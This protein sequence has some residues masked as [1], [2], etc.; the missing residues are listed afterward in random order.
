MM[1]PELYQKH[2]LYFIGL[3][4]VKTKYTFRWQPR[5]KFGIKL[6][7]SGKETVD[8]KKQVTWQDLSRSFDLFCIAFS[9]VAFLC[10]N[11]ASVIKYCVKFVKN[12]QR[13]EKNIN[14]MIILNSWVSFWSFNSI[15]WN[16]DNL[17][18]CCHIET[19]VFELT[20]FC[21]EY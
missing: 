19:D 14:V 12:L 11:L 18:E 21:M 7:E 20:I 9:T 8:C 5:I 1:K 10:I 2:C 17:E 13:T 16:S 6:D 3:F 15:K 4:S